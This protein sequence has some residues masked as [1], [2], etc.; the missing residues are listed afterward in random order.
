MSDP[1]VESTKRKWTGGHLTITTIGGE[2]GVYDKMG[3][4]IAAF[5]GS[6]AQ[7]NARLFAK[8]P[9]LFEAFDGARQDINWML[10]NRHFLN[11]EQFDYIDAALSAA[12]GEG[13]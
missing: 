11:G 2:V 6:K 3:S 8:A 12:L 9:Q 4:L 1:K 13:E 5:H 10:N 7:A